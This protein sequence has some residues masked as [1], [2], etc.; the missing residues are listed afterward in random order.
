MLDIAIAIFI[1]VIVLTIVETIL[2]LSLNKW[3]Y[4]IGIKIFSYKIKMENEASTFPTVEQIRL[5]I[6]DLTVNFKFCELYNNKIAFRET[7]F[8]WKIRN[9]YTPIM[10]GNLIF[11]P[12]SREVEVIGLLHW[13]LIYFTILLIVLSISIP[14]FIFIVFIA[15]ILGGSFNSVGLHFQRKRYKELAR[16]ISIIKC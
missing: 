12:T 8:Q 6:L 14:P 11:H 4:D 3:Y 13:S 9:Q 2:F 10:R 7:A 1:I 16:R 15:I 5:A